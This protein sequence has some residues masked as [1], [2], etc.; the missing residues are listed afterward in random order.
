MFSKWVKLLYDL[1]FF[2]IYTHLPPTAHMTCVHDRRQT[3]LA[4]FQWLAALSCVPVTWHSTA[5]G[6]SSSTDEDD[7]LCPLRR[8]RHQQKAWR[9]RQRPADECVGWW[10]GRQP[11]HACAIVR[12]HSPDTQLFGDVQLS[13]MSAGYNVSGIFHSFNVDIITEW[14][15][16]VGAVSLDD[17]LPTN[18]IDDVI[19]CVT[20]RTASTTLHTVGLTCLSG[21]QWMELA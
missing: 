2:E 15:Q 11:L 1:N 17:G 19:K 7:R 21:F 12:W 16:C 9:Q 5:V 18:N 20:P 13:I 14:T 6:R 3:S 4:W 8:R 10:F